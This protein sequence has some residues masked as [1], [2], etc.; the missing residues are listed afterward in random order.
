MGGWVGCRSLLPPPLW[1]C[2]SSLLVAPPTTAP[3]RPPPPPQ[4]YRA[5]LA[6]DGQDVA[7]KVQRPGVEA[8]I[9]LDVY[10][11]R[12]AIGVVQQAAG[13]TRDLR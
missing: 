11:L 4:V 10:L 3:H 7:V 12:Q 9:A 5:T 8:T 6:A 1:L 2:C 13:V